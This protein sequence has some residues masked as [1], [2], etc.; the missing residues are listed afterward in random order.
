STCPSL[1]R[2]SETVSDVWF[3]V[4]S[5]ASFGPRTKSTGERSSS[6]ATPANCATNQQQTA[7]ADTRLFRIRLLQQPR[8]SESG[9][10]EMFIVVALVEQTD[11]TAGKDSEG[12]IGGGAFADQSCMGPGLTVVETRTDGD[13]IA[14]LGNG[15][16]AEKQNPVRVFLF[17]QPRISNEA[18]LADR[19]DESRI[20]VSRLP[21]RA[22]VFAERNSATG[23]AAIRA[24]V[25]HER[26][27]GQLDDRALVHAKIGRAA[28]LP[29]LAVIVGIDDVRAA[30]PVPVV[31]IV[32]VAVNAVIAGDDEAAFVFAASELNAVAWPGG[33]PV[34]VTLL[35]V[36]RNV[37]GLR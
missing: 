12:G 25:E 3:T 15:G 29:C 5:Q 10:G 34:P 33:I 18:G 20:V 21:G 26:A 14:A 30:G 19:F 6:A 16:V 11:L 17:R 35:G 32:F 37:A 8:G 1:V 36:S 13:M 7:I 24:A 27:I 28:E 31:L 22:A 4:A 23:F 2:T 9:E